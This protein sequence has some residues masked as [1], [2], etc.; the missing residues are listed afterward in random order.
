MLDN[1]DL[2][3]VARHLARGLILK[4]ADYVRIPAGKSEREKRR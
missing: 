3:R 1:L 2:A 4:G